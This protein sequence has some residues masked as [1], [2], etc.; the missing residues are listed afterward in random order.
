MQNRSGLLY[1]YPLSTIKVGKV[2]IPIGGGGYL[3]IFPYF[4]NKWGIKRLNNVERQPAIVY[5][6]PWELDPEQPRL[7]SSVLS[8]FRHYH[9]LHKTEEILRSLLQDFQFGKMKD[10]YGLQQEMT[11]LKS[12]SISGAS[13]G[14]E[15]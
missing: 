11:C 8:H 4:L 13:L 15:S 14:S 9:N 3:R 5:L 1:E 12:S 6:H 2:N 7:K 10:L